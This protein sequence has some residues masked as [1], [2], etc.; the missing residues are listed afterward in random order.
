MGCVSSNKYIEIP[1]IPI[2]KQQLTKLN[3]IIAKNNLTL[4]ILNYKSTINLFQYKNTSNI[5]C[6]VSITNNFKNNLLNL[7]NISDEFDIINILLTD[8][9]YKNIILFLNMIKMKIK[10]LIIVNHETWDKLR[11]NLDFCP[12][13]F[14]IINSDMVNINKFAIFN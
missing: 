3:L 4:K 1:S 11:L 7:I 14:Y 5:D 12:K 10:T 2:I 8:G 13:E 6:I 9:L